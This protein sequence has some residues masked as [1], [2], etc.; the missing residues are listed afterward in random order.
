MNW[1]RGVDS[2]FQQLTGRNCFIILEPRP[3]YCD[4]GNFIAKIFV[5]GNIVELQIDE[6]DGWPRYYFDETRARLE[7]EA[8]LT[9]RKQAPL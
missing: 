8:W 5:T 7:C 3:H 9:K 6:Q 4:R 1:S 2:D